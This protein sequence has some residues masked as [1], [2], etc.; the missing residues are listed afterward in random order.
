MK[1]LC[2][3]ALMICSICVSGVDVLMKNG[4]KIWNDRVYVLNEL[5]AEYNFK[6]PVPAQHCSQ[7]NIVFPAG[8]QKALVAICSSAGAAG[9]EKKIRS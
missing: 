4:V 1:V 5:P 2:F 3:T 8:P 9:V 7:Y 6:K